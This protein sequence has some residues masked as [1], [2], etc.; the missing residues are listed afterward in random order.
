[1]APFQWQA[2][3]SLDP[4]GNLAALMLRGPD[5]MAQAALAIGNAKAQA[6]QQ[7]GQ[8]WSGAVS[9]IGQSIAAIPQQQAQARAQA[10]E[11]QIR[12]AQLDDIKQRQ[13]DLS[14]LDT[15]YSQ[16]GGRDKILEAVPGHLKA[17]VAKGFA[18]ADEAAAKLSTAQTAAASAADAYTLSFAQ[19]VKAHDYDPAALMLELSHA[20]QTFS[21]NP[22]MLSQVNQF[23]QQLQ[24]NPT[25]D[26]VKSIIDPVI[27]AHLASQGPIKG[28]AGDVFFNPA[29]LAG[30]PLARVPTNAERAATLPPTPAQQADIDYKKSQIK[31]IDAKL[32]GSMPLTAQQ[33]GEL[34]IS[35]DRLNAEVA[36]WRN[37]D[38]AANPFGTLATPSGGTGVAPA[39]PGSIPAAPGA[40]PAGPTTQPQGLHGDDLLKTLPP[41]VA[42]EVKAYAE[43]KLPFP[44]GMSVAKLQP[45][46]QLVGQ[47]DPTF[48]AANYT[49]RSKARVDLTSP[50]GTGAKTINSM[51][52]ALQHAGKLSDLIETLNNSE[53]P[54][55][56]AV[57][58]PLKSATG[59][60]AVTNFNAVAPQL[61]K[62]IERAWRGAG[63][64]A[65]EIAELV[66]SIGQNQGKQQQREALGQ[67]V[68]L[69]KGKLDS[70]QQQRDNALGAAGSSIPVLFDQNV[71]IMNT[72]AQ[73]ASG[74]ATT[75]TNPFR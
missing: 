9:N 35:R 47:Y 14:A 22:A 31:E 20:K 75:R 74:V 23:E 33:Q 61:M 62:E 30:P 54:I 42:Q 72:I 60:T 38:Q 51:N 69:L 50:N 66:K 49:A 73:R 48:D 4:N 28:A 40:A 3:P 21:S 41:G 56:N 1:M 15:A 36:H 13:A 67:F 26:G 46:I 59:N 18:D 19:R 2:P 53:Y 39:Q 58:N 8:A 65:G 12:Q 57:V 34:K 43:G 55:A 44:T 70:V 6:A 45:L 17:T 16:P 37:Q 27:Q 52:T 32:S 10:Q 71:P 7:T 63:G 5:A 11:S 29:D 24:Q 25:A 64:S 68:D